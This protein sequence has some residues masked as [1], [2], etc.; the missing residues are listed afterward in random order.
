[1]GH[2]TAHVAEIGMSS[3]KD[4]HLLARDENRIIV[5]L[6]ADFHA[7]LALSRASAPSTIRI[8][9]QGLRGPDIADLVDRVVKAYHQDLLSGG[10]VTVTS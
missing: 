5:T 7:I 2:D 3:A 4:E 8:R 1:M 10:A 6:D 9:K